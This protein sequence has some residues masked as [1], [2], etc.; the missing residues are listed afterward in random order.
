[1]RSVLASAEMLERAADSA[2]RAQREAAH[3]VEVA[4]GRRLSRW[5]QLAIAFAA[6]ATAAYPYAA[7]WVR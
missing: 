7:P 2:A 5:T 1:M 3:T 4:K 6:L